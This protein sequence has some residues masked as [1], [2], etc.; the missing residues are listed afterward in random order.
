MKKILLVLSM[1][2]LYGCS[3]ETTQIQEIEMIL[4]K[5]NEKER[6]G[7]GYVKKLGQYE[8]KEQLVFTAIME[9]T[10]QRHF[11]V[12]KSVTTIK[13]IA[14]DRLAM[15][16]KEQKTFHDARVEIMQ[17]Q[18]SLRNSDYDQRINKLFTALYDRYD[19]H[20]QLVAN[21]KQLV[22][23][24]LELYTQL[25]NLSVQPSELEEYVERVNSLA[26]DV[27]GNVRE[28]NESTIEVNRL[29]SR[30]LSS[31]EKNK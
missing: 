21:Y 16:T 28:F 17:L 7:K 27:E 26:D 3:H 31:L 20:D 22:Y 13:K 30:I 19:M 29:L 25:E 4:M 23:A 24:Q 15:I 14:N 5:V 9:L 2:F 6:L 12:R 10:Q 8:E 1:I 11:A 18:E